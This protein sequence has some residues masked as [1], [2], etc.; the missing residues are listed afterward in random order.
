MAKR[1]PLPLNVS[2]LEQVKALRASGL[3]YH[4]ISKRLGRDH[5]TIKKACLKPEVTSEIEV[6]KDDLSNFF[7]NLAKRMII[8]ITDE[9]IRRIN[10]YQRPLS[11]AISIDKTRLL[12]DQSTENIALHTIVEQVER[13]E[14]ERRAR[15]R[16][17][18][19]AQKGE[20]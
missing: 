5:K 11:A 19:A 4:A 18:E 6:I 3:T 20:E 16:Q 7:E 8:S 17:K 15:E 13:E 14:R 1:P 10:A 9:D 2:E 12:R